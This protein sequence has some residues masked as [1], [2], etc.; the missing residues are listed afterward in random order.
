MSGRWIALDS[1]VTA[2][3]T[4]DSAA[5]VIHFDNGAVMIFEVSWALNAPE[6]EYTQICASLA[7][8]SINPLTIYGEDSGYLTDNRPTTMTV[9]PFAVEIDHFIDCVRTGKPSRSPIEHGVAME[10]MLCG[11]YDSAKAGREISL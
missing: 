5:G 6:A 7:G 11:I 10:K 2:F 8:A 1:D 3:D 4:E 9:N